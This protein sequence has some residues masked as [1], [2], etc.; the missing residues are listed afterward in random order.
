MIML[1][2]INSA[3]ERWRLSGLTAPPD[4][5]F[6]KLSTL[7]TGLQDIGICFLIGKCDFVRCDAQNRSVLSV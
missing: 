6:E 7:C 3:E 5:V 4:P 1:L 2:G